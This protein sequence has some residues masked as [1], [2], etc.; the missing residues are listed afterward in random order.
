MKRIRLFILSVLVSNIV[1]AQD[2][3]YDA[4]KLKPFIIFD[5]TLIPNA[6]PDTTFSFRGFRFSDGDINLNGERDYDEVLKILK[7]YT[8]NISTN[9]DVFNSFSTNNFINNYLPGPPNESKNIFGTV[10]RGLG[11]T[12]V[13]AFADGLAKF[14]VERTKEELNEAFFRKFADFL[15][16]Y[17]EFKTLFPN[18]NVVVD[19]FNSWEYANLLNTLKEAFDKDIKELLSNFIKLRSLAPANCPKM[20]K[21][22]KELCTNCIARMNSVSG[23][24]KTNGGLFIL[25]A[26]QIG[27]GILQNQKIPDIINSVAQTGFLLGYTDAARPQ[28]ASDLKN[29]L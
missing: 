23:F 18:T 22:N 28:I 25:S 2:I 21:N 4:I 6:P 13:T 17:P 5:S 15:K 26:A 8:S 9:T 24:F 12:D 16:Y 3:F 29:S 7:N 14:L 19:N 10:I 27:S 1:L 20:A 11:N